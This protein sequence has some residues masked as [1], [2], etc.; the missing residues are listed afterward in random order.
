ME[1]A[2]STPNL[3]AFQASPGLPGDLPIPIDFRPFFFPLSSTQHIISGKLTNCL[4][5]TAFLVLP[6]CLLVSSFKNA[7][8]KVASRAQAPAGCCECLEEWGTPK[9]ISACWDQ[10]Q[11]TDVTLAL[12]ARAAGTVCLPLSAEFWG[13]PADKPPR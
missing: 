2:G 11:L 1:L 4:H 10:V 5:D 8:N 7:I 13:F 12:R 6:Y 9:A 3:L